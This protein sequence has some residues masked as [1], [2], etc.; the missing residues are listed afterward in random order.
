MIVIAYGCLYSVD[1]INNT[2]W[3]VYREESQKRSFGS[4][5]FL[6]KG[7]TMLW[8]VQVDQ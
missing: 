2:K 6:V 7:M 3:L 5:F 4:I 8:T 1:Y